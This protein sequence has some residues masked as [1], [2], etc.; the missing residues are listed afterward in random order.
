MPLVQKREAFTVLFRKN[1]AD[2]ITDHL[3]FRSTWNICREKCRRA[4]FSERKGLKKAYISRKYL[5]ISLL[6]QDAAGSSP[7]TPT[8]TGHHFD[9]M[10]IEAGVRFV[11]KAL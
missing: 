7:V 2:H 10:C 5:V 3:P 9:T 6:E 8:K 4:L 11:R 1:P